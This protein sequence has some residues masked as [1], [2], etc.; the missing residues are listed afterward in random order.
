MNANVR[1]TKSK[2]GESEVDTDLNEILTDESGLKMA[3]MTPVWELATN[4]KELFDALLAAEPALGTVY[5]LFRKK[6]PVQRQWAFGSFGAI[7]RPDRHVRAFY[8]HLDRLESAPGGQ[9]CI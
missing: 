1:R 5:K 4:S 9:G 7:S 2:S 8:L 6:L 3:P